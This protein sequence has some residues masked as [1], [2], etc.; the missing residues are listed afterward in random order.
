MCNYLS[1]LLIQRDCLGVE[2]FDFVLC[3]GGARSVRCGRSGDFDFYL[4]FRE[5]FGVDFALLVER[6][7]VGVDGKE[8]A[9]SAYSRE[10]WRE[11]GLI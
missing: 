7:G 4:S 8:V 5:C 2:F 1:A 3:G 10:K 9:A 6:L 11:A